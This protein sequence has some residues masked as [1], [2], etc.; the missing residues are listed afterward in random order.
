MSTG[1][2]LPDDVEAL[3]AMLVEARVQLAIRTSIVPIARPLTCDFLRWVNS[4]ARNE[5]LAMRIDNQR[6]RAFPHRC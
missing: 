6:A 5:A 1:A 4:I 3:K 2:D